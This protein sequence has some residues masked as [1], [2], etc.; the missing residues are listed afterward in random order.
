MNRIAQPLWNIVR[1][2]IAGVLFLLEPIVA[3]VCGVGLVLGI[4]ASVMFEIS[5]VG[6]KFPFLQVLSIALSFGVMLFL[7]YALLSLFVAD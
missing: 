5:A 2:P 6:P 1:L 7:Y 4:F 3:F